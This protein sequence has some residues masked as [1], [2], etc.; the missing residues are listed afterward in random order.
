MFTNKIKQKNWH[1][2]NNIY[3]MWILTILFLTPSGNSDIHVYKPYVHAMR[4]PSNHIG[5]ASVQ[6]IGITKPVMTEVTRKA[7]LDREPKWIPDTSPLKWTRIE[8]KTWGISILLSSRAALPH[9]TRDS[10]FV[11]VR[12]ANDKTIPTRDC[13]EILGRATKKKSPMG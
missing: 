1:S 11:P 4:F 2:P 8:P 3:L 10:L 12:K 13:I 7:T 6:A 9:S 5:R